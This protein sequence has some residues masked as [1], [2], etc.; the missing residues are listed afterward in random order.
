MEHRVRDAILDDIEREVG[1]AQRDIVS[2]HL[3][4]IISHCTVK[5]IV[6]G[7]KMDDNTEL[8]R[9]MGADLEAAERFD[10]MHGTQEKHFVSMWGDT[11]HA[12][13]EYYVNTRAPK[14]DHKAIVHRFHYRVVFGELATPLYNFRQL[15]DAVTT[16][17]DLVKGNG[18]SHVDLI[19]FAHCIVK[20]FPFFTRLAGCT[21]ISVEEIPFNGTDRVVRSSNLVTWNL[22]R[23][24][25]RMEDMTLEQ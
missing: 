6:N 16:L 23:R 18:L 7:E 15:S 3:F 22:Q 12:A 8:P 4:T 5:A 10:V 1:T 24:W 13:S 17:C 21:V 2:R 25:A 9:S 19:T 11:P 20:S 14:L